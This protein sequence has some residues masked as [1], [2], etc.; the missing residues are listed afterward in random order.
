M[1]NYGNFDHYLSEETWS[2]FADAAYS[3]QA[4]RERMRRLKEDRIN[5]LPVGTYISRKEWEKWGL[6]GQ[7]WTK[8][9]QSAWY[10][11]GV[12]QTIYDRF[13]DD[14]ENTLSL[15]PTPHTRSLERMVRETGVTPEMAQNWIS[16]NGLYAW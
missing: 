12:P 10:M 3:A 5:A 11:N 13:P 4:T 1:G 8:A 9:S 15:Q 16:E 2:I 7:V 6:F 14:L